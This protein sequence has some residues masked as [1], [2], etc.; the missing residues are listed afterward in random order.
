VIRCAILVIFISAVKVILTIYPPDVSAKLGSALGGLENGREVDKPPEEGKPNSAAGILDW[1]SRSGDIHTTTVFRPGKGVIRKM[2]VREKGRVLDFPDT[3]TMRMTDEEINILIESE[4]PGKV[5]TVSL[6]FLTTWAT[7]T[8]R[9][10]EMSEGDCGERTT[11]RSRTQSVEPPRKRAVEPVEVETVA[12][13]NESIAEEEG[14][15]YT[16]DW[17]DP[18][19]EHIRD[20][21]T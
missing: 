13:D 20:K 6:Y 11:K 19:A 5:V 4:I 2:T 17:E 8:K 21:A 10:R 9:A 16:D 15:N 18:S 7:A 3:Q 1:K 14:D 12:E